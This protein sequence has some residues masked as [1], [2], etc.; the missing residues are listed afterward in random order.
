MTRMD[1]KLAL[2]VLA[3]A[4]SAPTAAMAQSKPN[5]V[6]MVM[7]NLGWGE[8]GVYGG[9]ILRG[10]ETPRIDISSTDVRRRVQRHQSILRLV[11]DS[12]AHYI[13]EHSLYHTH[14]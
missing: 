3:C 9:G 11:P 4:L 12:V 13:Q 6:L 8:V 7:D 14:T 1:S 10:A 2:V 5:I